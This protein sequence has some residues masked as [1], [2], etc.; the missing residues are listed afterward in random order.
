MNTIGRATKLAVALLVFGT[1]TARGSE[2]QWSIAPPS[3]FVGGFVTI[4]I[5]SRDVNPR[6]VTI[7]LDGEDPMFLSSVGPVLQRDEQTYVV[8]FL[9]LGRHESR[10][11]DQ[12]ALSPLFRNAGVVR[13]SLQGGDL[14]TRE[15]EV[16][17]HPLTD[18]ARAAVDLLYPVIY[19][20]TPDQDRRIRWI[21]LI[22]G[23]GDGGFSAYVLD[24]EYSSEELKTL[25]THPDWDA[26][27]ALAATAR[28][29]AVERRAFLEVFQRDDRG[30]SKADAMDKLRSRR[31][32]VTNAVATTPVLQA[33]R[34]RI[35]RDFDELHAAAA[36]DDAGH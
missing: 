33:V 6:E 21:R 16:V 15:Y 26:P 14:A 34:E 2:I 28:E 30:A 11:G 35:T 23:L 9:H 24:Y 12:L 3:V 10:S 32:A 36:P 17:V 31:N 5:E 1:I 18:E 20:E 13:V 19:P 7:K 22:S 4:E 27:L 8:A 25:R 29:Y